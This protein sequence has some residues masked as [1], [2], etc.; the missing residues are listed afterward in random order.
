MDAHAPHHTPCAPVASMLAHYVIVTAQVAA[1]T[2]ITEYRRY[3]RRDRTVNCCANRAAHATAASP[4]AADTLARLPTASLR[5]GTAPDAHGRAS[6]RADA[7]NLRRKCR[8][9]THESALQEHPAAVQVPPTAATLGPVS[10]A[11]PQRP[12]P[13]GH[14]L[15]TPWGSVARLGSR[16]PQQLRRSPSARTVQPRDPRRHCALPD[17]RTGPC[18]M[19]KMHPKGAARMGVPGA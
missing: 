19:R 17:G 18:A 16:S 6:P 10:G 3:R 13:P 9:R 2:D 7:P 8:A 12:A 4:C 15:W 1:P 14:G 5:P 11:V